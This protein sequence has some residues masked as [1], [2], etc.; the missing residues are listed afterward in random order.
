[1][2]F[3][4]M[5]SDPPRMLKGQTRMERR[6]GPGSRKG[7]DDAVPK[8]P[9]PPL[10]RWVQ[11]DASRPFRAARVRLHVLDRR[12]RSTASWILAGGGAPIVPVEPSPG[13]RVL[14]ERILRDSERA[15]YGGEGLARRGLDLRPR[16]GPPPERREDVLS[17]DA[18]GD[19]SQDP[20][21]VRRLPRGGL[22]LRG[23]GDANRV[24]WRPRLSHSR[25]RRTRLAPRVARAPRDRG[26]DHGK[27]PRRRRGLPRICILQARVPGTQP[28]R[29]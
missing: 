11:P 2:G 7:G 13:A 26:L 17:G 5:A 16:R 9:V 14:F 27:R 6:A 23:K 29:S 24:L 10:L 20:A 8:S 1:M 25:L 28:Q 18:R 22:R 19:P 12:D 15:D 4:S 3:H 21:F